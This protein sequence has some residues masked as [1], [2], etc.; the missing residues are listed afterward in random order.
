VVKLKLGFSIFTVVPHTSASFMNPIAVIFFGLLL[1][2]SNA[3]ACTDK[4]E[5]VCGYWMHSP[6]TQTFKNECLMREGGAKKR[7]SG[8][9]M[10]TP[11]KSSQGQMPVKP[12]K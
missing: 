11:T 5:P 9:C 4:F 12:G 1:A 10:D 8:S 3:V 2:M 7:H 6:K